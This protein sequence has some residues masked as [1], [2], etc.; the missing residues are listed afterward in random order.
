M[1][2]SRENKHDILLLVDVQEEFNIEDTR[3]VLPY[4]EDATRQPWDQVL[5]TLFINE[6]GS[7]FR[8]YLGY[9][10]VQDDNVL[11]F[12][13]E[14]IIKHGYSIDVEAL[15]LPPHSSVTLMGFDTEACVL[16]TAFSLFDASHS[17][18]IDPQGCASSGGKHLHDATLLIAERSF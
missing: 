1:T 12:V 7:P 14:P 8:R 5:S 3:H 17:V 15:D 11:S 6:P 13:P 2:H 9:T 16:A 4:I 18:F 10:A